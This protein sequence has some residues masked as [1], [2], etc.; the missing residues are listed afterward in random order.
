MLRT[1]G[2]KLHRA[3]KIFIILKKI[4]FKSLLNSILNEFI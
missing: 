2:R 3:N 4:Q 1:M